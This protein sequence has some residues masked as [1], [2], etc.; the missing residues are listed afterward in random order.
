MHKIT[1]NDGALEYVDLLHFYVIILSYS[2]VFKHI[3]LINHLFTP[4]ARVLRVINSDEVIKSHAGL[5]LVEITQLSHLDAK[6][7]ELLVV[8]PF[9]H[10]VYFLFACNVMTIIIFN[11]PTKCFRNDLKT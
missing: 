10:A 1:R 11:M 3:L 8:C 5:I 2:C 9:D 6:T 7:L 4:T